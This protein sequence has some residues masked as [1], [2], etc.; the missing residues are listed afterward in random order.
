MHLP[1]FPQVKRT[2][3]TVWTAFFCSLSILLTVGVA[4][5]LAISTP[6]LVE[7][8][9]AKIIADYQF[10]DRSDALKDVEAALA[11]AKRDGKL[12]MIVMGANW[13]HDSMGLSARFSAPE[14]HRLLQSDFETVFINVGYLEY[15]REVLARFGLYAFYG[16]PTVMIIEPSSERILNRATQK[17]WF[18]ADSYSLDD[19]LAHF[20]GF[21]KDYATN[22]LLLDPDTRASLDAIN[23]FEA[24]QAVRLYKGYAILGPLL[25][26]FEDH[27]DQRTT[28]SQLELNRLWS[29]IRHFRM[30]L[31]SSL[32]SLR[33]RARAN[34]AF[35]LPI[36]PAM[37]FEGE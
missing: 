9:E 26:T 13:C 23:E 28:D 14:M 29:E 37:S 4:G 11:S 5:L 24:A 25:R 36:Y 35:E 19:Y 22:D 6:A 32:V 17:R 20:G 1:N 2:Y 33:A 30:T 16:T 34:E 7:T 15:G 3:Y 10:F 12:L 31:I 8:D 18:S 27:K 21:A